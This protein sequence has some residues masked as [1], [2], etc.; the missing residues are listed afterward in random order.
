ME[1]IYSVKFGNQ[2]VGKV[3]VQ[4]QGLYYRFS[5]RC[6]LTGSVVYRLRIMMG[7]VCENLGV[8]I[9]AD[10]GFGLDTKIPVKRLKAGKPEFLL[11]PKHNRSEGTYI[12]VYPEEP[13]AYISR[14]KEAYLVRK[15]G[16]AG[17]MLR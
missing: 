5:C 10:G 7:D 13:F 8:L 16:Q 17:I 3:S 9:P 14:L 6:H 2:A 1:G 4:R 11:I 12:P 15:N